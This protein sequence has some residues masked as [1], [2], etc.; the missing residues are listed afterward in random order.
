MAGPAGT[1]TGAL[2]VVGRGAGNPDPAIGVA[3]HLPDRQ[4]ALVKG[5]QR[6]QD[7]R[8]HRLVLAQGLD[9]SW[10]SQQLRGVRLAGHHPNQVLQLRDEQI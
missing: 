9:P 10:E 4:A 3:P 1:S 7:C 8:S 5:R 6:R 2:V